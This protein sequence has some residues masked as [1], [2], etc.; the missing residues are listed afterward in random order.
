MDGKIRDTAVKG[1]RIKVCFLIGAFVTGGKERQLAETI[2][3]LPREKYAVSLFFRKGN[4]AYLEPGDFENHLEAY[5]ALEKGHFSFSDMLRLRKFLLAQRPEIIFS[6]SDT[7]AHFATILR[8]TLPFRF[9]LFNGSIREAPVKMRTVQRIEKFL[10]R[11]YPLVVA[12]SFAGLSAYGIKAGKGKAVWYNG[13]DH[14][15]IPTLSKIDLRKNLGLPEDYLVVTMVAVICSRKDHTTFVRA[16]K[17]VRAH[18]HK[19]IFLAVGDGEARGTYER[20]AKN[21]GLADTVRFL[22][23]RT[24]IEAIL[25]ATDIS[26]L[27]SMKN[28]GEGISNAILESMACGLPVIATDNGG[29]R[30]IIEDGRSGYIVANADY[31]SIAEKIIHLY[32]HPDIAEQFGK[33]GKEI[34]EKKFSIA[35]MVQRFEEIIG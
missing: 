32:R 31:R 3:H 12:N 25:G 21:E 9:R 20:M 10:Y 33:R 13:F 14:M 6:F 7:L 1:S 15:R 11:F 23:S 34:V 16:A 30:E 28:H 4:A 18:T 5:F 26:V 29:T 2:K 27:A 17:L 24:D 35:A 8:M 19:C 22:G